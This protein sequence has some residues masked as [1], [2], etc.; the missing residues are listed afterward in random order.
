MCGFPLSLH[1]ML[2]AIS[3][4]GMLPCCQNRLGEHAIC[5]IDS[6]MLVIDC[7]SSFADVVVRMSGF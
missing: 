5:E 4:R 2:S 6:W 7:E 3:V 1:V